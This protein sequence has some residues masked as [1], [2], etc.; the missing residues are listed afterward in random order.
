[1]DLGELMKPKVTVGMCIKN[2]AA[3]VEE[4][5]K[6]LLKQDF[7][8]ELME[9]IIVDGGS[10]DETLNIIMDCL[11]KMK[12]KMRVRIFHE[13][14]GLGRQRQIVVEN[15]NGKYIL[16][17]DGDMILSKN[18]VAKIVKF[19]E[20]NPNVGI[21]KGIVSTTHKGSTLSML[22]TLSRY[23]RTYNI[24]YESENAYSKTL[25]TGG[26]V[27]RTK[28]IR[29]IGGFDESLKY[30]CED[31]DVEIKIKASG[32]LR[33]I[34]NVKYLDYER[35]RLT[36]KDLW[37]KYWLRGYYTHY[38]LHKHPGLIKH[39]RMFPPAAFLA[40]LLHAHK[41][42]KL[43]RIKI[44]FLLPLQYVFKSVAWYMGFLVSH[45]HHYKP[46]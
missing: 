4:A 1:M 12:T 14:G 3:T 31:W 41:L 26:S 18:Y 46:K 7:P 15:A 2:C 24:D 29:Q 35:Y 30:Y 16:W 45:L 39:Y 25:G 21:A 20:Q 40:G 8:H 36:W 6:S 28:A 37:K 19:M 32:W 23:I 11:S 33:A 13:R 44:V 17:I 43:S 38:F 27:Y 34:T 22:E 9:L 10:E 42:F 5:I